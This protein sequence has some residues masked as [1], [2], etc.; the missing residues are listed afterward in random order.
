M[1]RN[2]IVTLLGVT[3]ILGSALSA[4]AGSGAGAIV[5]SFPVGARYNALGEAGTAL[6]QDATAAWYNAG[7]MAFIGDR[8]TPHD[9]Q[10]MYSPLAA[11]L[12]DDIALTWLGY[13]GKAG[14]AGAI[15]FSLTYLDMG[16]QTATDEEGNV[17]GTFSSYEF[18]LQGNYALKLSPN[19]GLGF[20]VK[21][22]RD[23]LADDASL[24]DRSGGSGDSFGVD[25][26]VLWKIPSARLNVGG[27]IANLG[28]DIKHVDADQ[29]DP[30]PRKAT[31]GLGWGLIATE[32]MGL[33]LVGDYQ[34]PL[35]KW[36]G[37]SYTFGFDNSQ[38]EWGAGAEWNYDRMLFLRAGYKKAGYGDIADWTFGFGMDLKKLVGQAITFDFA[39]VPQAKGLDRVNR[40]SL[41]YR[42]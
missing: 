7:G 35:Y 26:G 4:L 40:F 37:D 27:S 6:A 30:M 42:W 1:K 22:F 16:E 28:P 14:S 9:I 34:V 32:Y 36:E 24:Q 3:C 17:I 23:K 39:S 15:G 10:I 38:N 20:G 31:L 41:G 8:S 25:L 21:Y 19:L 12:A 11:G 2:L 13:A 5:L 29:A 18:V 33:L